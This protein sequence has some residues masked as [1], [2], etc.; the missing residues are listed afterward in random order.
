MAGK[1]RAIVSQI[2]VAGDERLETAENMAAVESAPSLL[3]RRDPGN[4]YVLIEAAGDPYGID[5]L[6]SNMMDAAKAAYFGARGSITLGLRDAVRAAN[7]ALFQ[8]NLESPR[9][10]RRIGGMSCVVLRQD[11]VY[12]AQAGPALVYV[13]SGTSEWR[14]PTES[15]WLDAPVDEEVEGLNAIP[16][17]VRKEIPVE[18]FHSRVQAGDRVLLASSSLMPLFRRVDI[19]RALGQDSQ[20]GIKDLMTYSGA[21]D[22]SLMVLD[23]VPAE[24]SESGIKVAPPTFFRPEEPPPVLREAIEEETADRQ[25]PTTETAADFQQGTTEAAADYRR[26]IVTPSREVGRPVT[27][28]TVARSATVIGDRLSA[29][30]RSAL[31]F[32]AILAQGLA[33]LLQRTLPEHKEV[34]TTRGPGSRRILIGIAL[35]IPV[36][37]AVVVLGVYWQARGSQGA[38]F[39]I[40]MEEAWNQRDAALSTTD[41]TTIRAALREADRNVESAL[42]LRPEDA[43]AQHLRDEILTRLDQVNGVVRLQRVVPIVEFKEQNSQP[44]RV[45]LYEASIYVLDR[46]GGRIYRYSLNEKRDGLTDPTA[47]VI[48]GAG[49]EHEGTVIAEMVDAALLNATD[50]VQTDTVLLLDQSKNLLR[51]DP[52]GDVTVLKVAEADQWQSPVLISTFNGNFYLLDRGSNRILKYVPTAA[53]YSAPPLDWLSE[54]TSVDFSTAVDMAVDG[55]IYVLLAQGTVLRFS[56]GLPEKFEQTDIDVPIHSATALYATP[57]TGSLYLAD[58]SNQR[59]VQFSKD[60]HFE[61]QFLPP[62][63]SEV[64]NQLQSIAVDELTGKIFA[65]SGNKLWVASMPPV[66]E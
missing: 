1:L 44:Q 57:L 33:S 50:L 61:R 49:E 26:P 11:D 28:E 20:K 16:L 4:L 45:L 62:D 21:G 55:A 59:I 40:F 8:E 32:L 6:Y 12:I 17:G 42:L 5:V 27:R 58:T 10:L 15:S 54:E 2:S 52:A 3:T 41:K 29:V 65:L 46:G 48:F 34:P 18:L 37:I 51:Y 43:E 31:S 56:E 35:A 39:Q 24:M 30:A 53:G 36:M 22:A 38:R 47:Q 14:F 60:G 66:G 9:D 63:E 64:F 13:L 19:I 25:L 7:N 23:L